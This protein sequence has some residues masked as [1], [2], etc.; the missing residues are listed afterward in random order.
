MSL[1]ID[2]MTSN[3]RTREK[4][5][6]AKH[7]VYSVSNAL[8]CRVAWTLFALF[9]AGLRADTGLLSNRIKQREKKKQKKKNKNRFDTLYT[10]FALL[11]NYGTINCLN[12]IV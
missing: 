11:D 3:L 2:T 1:H 7:A 5:R 10:V 9:Y 12:P 8:G 6:R 4:T